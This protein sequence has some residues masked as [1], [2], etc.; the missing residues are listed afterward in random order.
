MGGSDVTLPDSASQA[1]VAENSPKQVTVV[2]EG[3]RAQFRV[4]HSAERRFL[5]LIGGVQVEDLGTVF[6]VERGVLDVSIQV[7]EGRVRV[8]WQG[9]RAELSAGEQGRYPLAEPSVAND[10]AGKAPSASAAVPKAPV[11]DLA[12]RAEAREGRYK[13]AFQL[14]ERESFGSVRDEPSDLL[15]AADVARLSGHAEKALQPLRNLLRRH[16]AD[17]RCPAAA[18]TLGSVLLRDLGRAS[19]AAQAF[20]DAVRLAPSGNLS[21]DA[22]ARAA[23]AWFKAGQRARAEAALQRYQSQHPAGRHLAF[24]KRLIQSRD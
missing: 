20:E 12:W 4:K 15:L 6:H 3:G 22:A 11:A 14:L 16:R 7:L 19:E 1:R 17:P 9:Q 24:L 5:V 8:L 2:V 21:E 10:L 13:E 23:E 18:F